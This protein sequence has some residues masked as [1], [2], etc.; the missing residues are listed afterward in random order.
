MRHFLLVFL[1]T[2]VCFGQAQAP[3]SYFRSPLEIPLLLSGT[4]GELRSNH[5]HSGLDI[6]TQGKTGLSVFAA[7]DGYVKRIKISHF[8]YGKAIYI[9]HPNGY[10]SVY[11]HLENVSSKIDAY[12]RK[13]QY[14]KESYQI[15]L[16]PGAK[17]LPVTKGEIVAYTGNTGGSGGPH[18]HFELR[19]QN[20]RPMNPLLFG[21]A[22]KDSK[23]PIIRSLWT[24]PR[25][26]DSTS[27]INDL[28][29]AQKLRL[30]LQKDGT[31][32]SRTINAYGTIGFGVATIDRQDQTYN[33]NGVY[34][35]T[36][37]FNGSKSFEVVMNRFSF[38]ETRNINRHIDY[39]YYKEHKSRIQK[40]F[41]E[42]N[43]PLSIYKRQ[44]GNGELTISDGFA[45]N[46]EISIQDIEGNTTRIIVPIKGVAANVIPPAIDT[47][48]PIFL[49]HTEEF[50][51]NKGIF[52]V[53][54]PKHSLYKDEK[55]NFEVK[56]DTLHL[57]KDII[58]LHKKATISVDVK[59]YAPDDQKVM[60][61]AELTDRNRPLYCSTNKKAGR[62]TTKTRNFGRYTVAKDTVAP[63]ITPINFRDKKWISDLRYL[64]LK[65]H[66]SETG[67]DS[68]RGTIN[69]KFA[70]MEYDY[71]TK[72][73]FYD[74][75]DNIS[76][77]TENK[78]TFV[79]LDKVGNAT[80]YNATF[81]RK[82]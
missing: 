53:Y 24:Y 30:V 61:I 18:L 65:I 64:K 73:V 44:A 36:T 45:Y 43:D 47:D 10:T 59:N 52:D 58:P 34:K 35:I 41:I 60:Y 13:K 3:T 15:E 80:T 28:R 29:T 11:A 75:N 51:W 32:K 71:K 9:Q 69:G 82:N 21:L 56:G 1:V 37:K 67:I 4:F 38:G 27:H 55:V 23:K 40:L 74:F 66:D 62:F 57:F 78:F 33:K 22:V 42:E 20:S 14:D 16:Y 50:V 26:N 17:E 39:K 54:I 7:A 8:G 48:L 77:A 70:L 31:Y 63:I 2:Q 5:F 19:D 46:Y 76:T 49:N 72:T 6:K 79:V 25:Q 81:F 12:L 68:F